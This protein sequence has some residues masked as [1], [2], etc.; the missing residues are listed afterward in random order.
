MLA[1][2]YFSFS[3]SHYYIITN[4]TRT[5]LVLTTIYLNLANNLLILAAEIIPDITL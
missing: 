2:A 5:I 3:L 1:C 4:F